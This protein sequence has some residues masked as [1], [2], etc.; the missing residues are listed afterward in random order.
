[1]EDVR[2][3]PRL[4]GL[5]SVGVPSSGS[6]C[7]LVDHKELVIELFDRLQGR[8]LLYIRSFGLSEQ[9]GEDVLQE[10]FLSLFEHLSCGRSRENL[11]GWLFRVAHNLAIKSRVKSKRED[12]GSAALS[13][14]EPVDTSPTPQQFLEQKEAQRLYSAVLQ[15]LPEQDRCCLLLRA[16]GL[17]YRQIASLAGVSLGSVATSLSRSLARLARAAKR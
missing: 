6:V 3:N 4:L 10:T 12:A 15:A 16:E 13:I 7:G 1:M 2:L 5:H 9:D 8:L 17:K 11:H 14:P